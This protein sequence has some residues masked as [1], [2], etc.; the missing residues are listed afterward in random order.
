MFICGVKSIA[1]IDG[2][3]E[4]DGL[5]KGILSAWMEMGH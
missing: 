5:V 2:V 4:N 3:S 1:D